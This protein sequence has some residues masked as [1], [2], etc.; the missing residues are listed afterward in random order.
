MVDIIFCQIILET[1]RLAGMLDIPFIRNHINPINIVSTTTFHQF[2]IK[3][4][5]HGIEINHLAPDADFA[6]AM[7]APSHARL[8]DVLHI[9]WTK[10]FSQRLEIICRDHRLVNSLCDAGTV[11]TIQV[12]HAAPSSPSH[13][14]S[15]LPLEAYANTNW[16]GEQYF[17]LFRETVTSPL[18][19]HPPLEIC[20]IICD[21]LPAQVPDLHAFLESRTEDVPRIM[22]ISSLTF[23]INLVFTSVIWTDSFANVVTQLIQVIHALNSLPGI[24]IVDRRCPAVIRTRCVHLLEVIDFILDHHDEAQTLLQI[25]VG[26]TIPKEF[27]QIRLLLFPL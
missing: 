17:E 18:D 6:E 8:A 10:A 25:V 3:L 11:V 16:M 21:N 20:G 24:E 23:M 26:L 13:R 9:G 5:E 22:H 12:V 1:A 15:V 19:A 2:V 7:T 27:A 4:M 14:P